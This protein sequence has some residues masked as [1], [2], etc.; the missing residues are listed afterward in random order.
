[1]GTKKD[2]SNWIT[3]IVINQYA[4]G[5]GNNIESVIQRVYRATCGGVLPNGSFYQFI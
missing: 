3:F 2:F 4:K 1:M 5:A